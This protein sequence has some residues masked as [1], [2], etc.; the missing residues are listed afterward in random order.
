MTT[1]WTEFGF[2]QTPYRTTPLAPNDF[3]Y[4]LFT[5]RARG[6]SASF[7]TAMDSSDGSFV[8][9][10]G[11]VGIGKTSFVNIQQ[12]LLSNGG[13]GFGPSLIPCF[14]STPL[15]QE[16][17]PVALARRFAHE[18]ISNIER[19]CGQTNLAVPSA[20]AKIREWMFS[21][22]PMTS[23]YQITVGPLGIGRTVV[24]PPA[25]DA[26]LETW[27]DVLQLLATET[28]DQL[29]VQ[30]F[31]VCMENAENCEIRDLAKLLMGYRDILFVIE[32]IWWILIGPSH[33]Y[34]QLA[35]ADRRVSQRIK[36][37]GIELSHFTTE[38]FHDLIERRVKAYRKT[39]GAISPLS[40][41]VH[42]LL[43]QAAQG[44]VRFMLDTAT[45][46]MDAIIMQVREKVQISQHRSVAP[47]VLRTTIS[48][49][50]QK[51]L[52][53]K[54]IPDA[55]AKRILSVE[56]RKYVEQHRKSSEFFK[57]ISCF[58]DGCLTEGDYEKAGYDKAGQFRDEFLEPLRAEGLL[59]RESK[60]GQHQY[61]LKGFAWLANELK[62]EVQ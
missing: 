23:G 24:V 20:C 1:I 49:V 50:L 43:F 42:D 21:H 10:S 15:G 16:D 62:V 5:S 4:E 52:I 13:A 61:T 35:I 59:F 6:E 26:T 33:L 60:D 56:V 19:Y 41:N 44:E 54:Q 40:K 53:D 46:L 32:G 25:A 11:D 2:S 47:Q 34:E 45:T 37:S 9:V 17:T 7:L 51:E 39:E 58:A 57:K 14:T 18:A 48:R 31:I 22:K 3:D 29:N 27:R 36:G 28:R 38:E 55:L 12:H 30:G 8:I